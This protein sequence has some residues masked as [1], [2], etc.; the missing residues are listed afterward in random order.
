MSINDENE[1]MCCLGCGRETKASNGYCRQC[2]PV[3]NKGTFNK[4]CKVK[5]RKDRKQNPYYH[6][7]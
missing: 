4:S 2:C 5:E 3:Y 1:S 7:R 6:T